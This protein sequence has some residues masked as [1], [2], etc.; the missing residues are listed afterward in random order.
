MT[1]KPG[2]DQAALTRRERQIMDILYKRGRA[3]ANEVMR[4]SVRATRIIRRSARSCACSRRKGTSR[5]KKTACATSTC[6]RCRG[7]RRE[8]RR[9]GISSTRSSTAR[10]SRS[11]RR[12]SAAKARSF[13]RRTRSHRG[14]H[15]ESQ[16]RRKPMKMS[17]IVF[18]ALALSFLLRQRS[19]ALRHW[20]LAAGVACAAAMP[21]LG[22][23]VPVVAAAVRD[24]RR[25]SVDTRM[26]FSAAVSPT[27][28]RRQLPPNA[29][30]TAATSRA[31][32]GIRGA[33]AARS[34][35]R[36]SHIDLARGHARRVWRFS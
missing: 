10:P 14:A 16:E 15:R 23:L 26:P 11:W 35:C 29:N 8:N 30:V 28:P 13:G 19:A 1:P 32:F 5:M 17:L 6:R 22:A 9:C 18:G 36:R 25:R 20:V 31:P 27:A 33:A 2:N 24:A 21:L 3:T 34:A 12:C 4:R 7:A